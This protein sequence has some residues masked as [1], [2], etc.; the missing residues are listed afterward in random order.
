MV[1]TEGDRAAGVAGPDD[2]RRPIVVDPTTGTL[3]ALFDLVQN[4][5]SRGGNRGP[6]VAFVT[7][8]H[9]GVTWSKPQV[10]AVIR[11]PENE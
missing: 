2:R 10:V 3:Y 4:T 9:A 6:N 7:S 5:S 1:G 11:R 8:T